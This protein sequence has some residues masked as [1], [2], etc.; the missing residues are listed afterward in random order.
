MISEEQQDQAALHALGLLPADE[1]DRFE[2]AMEA[3]AEL[4]ELA[5]ALREATTALT[6]GLPAA[7]PPPALRARVLSEITRGPVAV[8][9]RVPETPQTSKVV[10]FRLPT[11]VPWAV[12][13]SLLALCGVLGTERA[14]LH[15]ELSEARAADPLAD[16]S[17]FNLAASEKGPTTAR[18]T[19]AWEPTRQQG[20]L[21]VTGLTAPAPG[22]DY[23][24]WAIGT[25][26]KGPISAGLVHVDASGT[27]RVEFRPV[28]NVTQAAA[29][30]VSLERAGGSN[31][32]EGPILL[33]PGS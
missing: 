22:K 14:R 15:R 33:A 8:A 4:R 3:D 12:A 18:A 19:V 2:R 25:D 30:A 32:N 21:R 6:Y 20:V 10:P 7:T 23:Q 11:W 9:D 16:V 17:L 29:F 1:A 5:H 24:L 13:A 26:G 27:A 28:A 31:H